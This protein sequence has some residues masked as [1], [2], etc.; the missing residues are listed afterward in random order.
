MGKIDTLKKVAFDPRWWNFFIQ[1]RFTNPR[2]RSKIA[3]RL[4]QSKPTATIINKEHAASAAKDLKT[5]G[6]HRLH[7]LLS[8]EQCE[9]LFTYFEAKEVIDPYRKDVQPFLPLSNGR[10]PTAH[11]AHHGARDIVDAPHLIDLANDPQILDAVG[12]FLGCKPTIGYMAVW[13]SFA[14]DLGPQQAENFHR[15]VDD[16]RFVKLFV[17]LTEV[18]GQSGP[19]KYVLHSSLQPKLTKIRRYQD[20][21]VEAAFG[22]SNIQTMTAQPGE[23]FLEDTYGFHKGQPV[24]CGHRLLFQ[25]MY[26][27]SGTPYAPKVPVGTLGP[28]DGK[29]DPWTNR[30]YLK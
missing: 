17:Y 4:A 5:A 22:S 30:F 7:A 3:D 6:L 27:L 21:E 24:Q 11:I 25:V 18:T 14:T 16:W 29:R 20:E 9:E 28:K 26:T 2:Y 13:W 15:D 19:H 1:R 8:P 12:Q 23:G 10:P